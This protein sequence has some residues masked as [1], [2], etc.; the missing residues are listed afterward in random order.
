MRRGGGGVG[1]VCV[2]VCVKISPY[3]VA[4]KRQRTNS[5][6]LLIAGCLVGLPCLS[7]MVAHMQRGAGTEVWRAGIV[8]PSVGCPKRQRPFP[9]VF[10]P[11]LNCS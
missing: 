1:C 6:A 10:P 5:R 2:C 3:S 11:G 8:P 9:T 4:G 7:Q